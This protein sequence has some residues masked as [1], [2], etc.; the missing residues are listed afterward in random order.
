MRIIHQIGEIWS[1]EQARKLSERGISVIENEF[2]YIKVEPDVFKTIK[3]L[4]IK[5]HVIHAVAAEFNKDDLDHAEYVAFTGLR[6]FG[7]PQPED[8]FDYLDDVYDTTNHCKTCRIVGGVQ[9]GPFRIKTDKLKY[10]AFGLE[11]THDEIFLSREIYQNYF[12]NRGIGFKPVLIHR[13]GKESENFV[14]LEIKEVPWNFEM[15]DMK[16]E[17][18]SDCNR[19]NYSPLFLD[20]LPPIPKLPVPAIFHGKEYFGNGAEAFKMIY[21]S[22]EIRQIFIKNRLARWYNFTPLRK[23]RLT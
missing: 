16:F 7:Y 15:S 17:F 9:K 2:S 6:S 3:D 13:T 1:G 14:Q 18:C 19:K 22:Q 12:R 21:I 11:W 10:G 5:P 4:V 20:F 23:V 8:T